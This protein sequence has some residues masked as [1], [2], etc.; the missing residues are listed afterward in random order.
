MHGTNNNMGW[1]CG[2]GEGNKEYMRNFCW[3][4]SWKTSTSKA[5]TE[6]KIKLI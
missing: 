6:D 4:T 1:T 3:E 5:G 2:N